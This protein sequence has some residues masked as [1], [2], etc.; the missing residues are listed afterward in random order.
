MP[1]S[2]ICASLNLFKTEFSYQNGTKCTMKTCSH[3]WLGL[4]LRLRILNWIKKNLSHRRLFSQILLN[5]VDCRRIES[6]YNRI[7]SGQW[8]KLRTQFWWF[9][10]KTS[11]NHQYGLICNLK[12][13]RLPK[14]PPLRVHLVIIHRLH[15]TE[16]SKQ[17]CKRSNDPK[18]GKMQNGPSQRKP[19]A[20]HKCSLER[21]DSCKVIIS[22][23]LIS[24]KCH[25]AR[26]LITKK[27]KTCYLYS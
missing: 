1:R 13:F 8:S 9:K 11:K 10:A 15:L 21:Q 27:M 5:P 23:T 16:L 3:S 24:V 20:S 22:S 6:I 7:G 2:R 14:S 12:W 4:S 17:S 25:S 26:R 19:F 18:L